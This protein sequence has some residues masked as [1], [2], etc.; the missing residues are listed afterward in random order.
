MA[1]CDYTLVY[2]VKI[3]SEALK[4]RFWGWRGEVRRRQTRL[5]SFGFTVDVVASGSMIAKDTKEQSGV[6]RP[7]LG[8][9]SLNG[10]PSHRVGPTSS[11][12]HVSAY[13]LFA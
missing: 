13:P 1:P 11:R 2:E 10:S 6:C 4:R 9:N 12:P 8:R 7:Q 5:E 3:C